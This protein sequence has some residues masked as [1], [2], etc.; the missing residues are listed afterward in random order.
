M[1]HQLMN[2]FDLYCPEPEESSLRRRGLPGCADMLAD[3]EAQ[4]LGELRW[5]VDSGYAR[6][7]VRECSV[8]SVLLLGFGPDRRAVDQPVLAERN[9]GQRRCSSA[10]PWRAR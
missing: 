5:S 2:P 3:R 1:Y 10:S 9:F 4:R 8:P 6:I 7:A